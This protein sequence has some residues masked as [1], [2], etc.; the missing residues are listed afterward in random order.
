MPLDIEKRQQEW[1]A[2]EQQQRSGAFAKR[3]HL[4]R[5][6]AMQYLFQAD[7]ANDWTWDEQNFTM[8]TESATLDDE[9]C[10]DAP[11]QSELEEAVNFARELT[12]GAMACTNEIDQAIEDA[13]K[14]WSIQRM[15]QADRAILRLAA[16]ELLHLEKVSAATTINEAVELAKQY[17]EAKSPR[18]INGVLDKIRSNCGKKSKNAPKDGK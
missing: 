15:D 7:S 14:N 13:A 10:D 8:F 18:F 9:E 1:L 6:L 17:G 5:V 3:R 2:H 16:Y 11:L 12:S 4:A